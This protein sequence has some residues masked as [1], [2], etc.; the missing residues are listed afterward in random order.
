[1]DYA[2]GSLNL[3]ILASL[4]PSPLST[5]NSRLHPLV[6]INRKHKQTF[7]MTTTVSTTVK[8][9][10]SMAV[11][12]A[13]VSIHFS[14]KVRYRRI[15]VDRTDFV[16]YVLLRKRLGMW[17]RNR[18]LYSDVVT[19]SFL[20]INDLT[21]SFLTIPNLK[22]SVGLKG[23]RKLNSVGGLSISSATTTGQASSVNFLMNTIEGGDNFGEGV[24]GTGLTS[25]TSFGSSNSF[26]PFQGNSQATGAA[27]GFGNS[28]ATQVGGVANIPATA[29]GYDEVIFGNGFAEFDASGGGSS[30]FGT[31]LGIPGTGTATAAVPATTGTEGT[32]GK[33]GKKGDKNNAAA[34]AA[35]PG[36]PA[37]PDV[38]LLGLQTGGGGGGF[39]FTF[40]GG[41]GNVSVDAGYSEAYGTAQS[42]G[43]GSGSGTSIFGTA[44]GSGGGTSNGNGGG[45]I[46]YVNGEFGD[47]IPGITAFNGTGGGLAS[48]GAAGFVGVAP[49]TPAVG[50]PST[51]GGP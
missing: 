13:L 12:A 39:G 47:Y 18:A 31:P 27:N 10:V 42:A 26:S 16:L 50:G 36:T 37:T 6:L 35:T 32:S 2:R 43:F 17:R 33:K 29:P 38:F 11:V 21:L 3:E 1:L 23:T 5:H 14:S 19:D 30:S 28:T 49:E 45:S 51:F 15:V 24:T 44:G 9:V 48:G 25:G 34:V 40:G 41:V 4:A 20:S 7:N 46:G 8:I 22:V